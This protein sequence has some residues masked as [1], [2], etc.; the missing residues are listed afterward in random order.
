MTGLSTNRRCITSAPCLHGQ[1]IEFVIRYYSETTRQPEKAVTP[2]EAAAL[3][4]AGLRLAAV[5][6]DRAREPVDFSRDSGQRDGEF[7]HAYARAIGQPAGTTIFFAVDY[8]AAPADY[9]RLR[10][11]FTAVGAALTAAASGGPAY[12]VGVY[13]SGYVCRRLT[14]DQ[15]V[16]HR[17]LAEATGWRESRDATGWDLKQSVTRRGLCDLPA[18]EWQECTARG[19]GSG[20]AF[21]PGAPAPAPRRTAPATAQPRPSAPLPVL[22][23]GSRGPEALTLQ[24]LLNRWLVNYTALLREDG[25]FGPRTLRAVRAF[26]TAHTDERGVSLTPDGVVGGITWAALH[27]VTSGE[28]DPVPVLTA[29]TAGGRPW[30][31]S[32]PAPSYGGSARAR[33]ALAKA[34]EEAVSGAREIG[35]N[36]SGPYVEKYLADLVTPPANWCAGFVSWCLR[37]SGP[38]PFPYTVG[39]RSLL[40]RARAAGLTVY[41]DPI[42]TPPLPGD[43]VVWWRVAVGGWQGHTGFVHRAEAGRLYTLEGNKTSRV[44]GFDYPLVGL[45]K[46]LGLV[47]V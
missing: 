7:A 28:P 24:R 30:W 18:G 6:Q 2:A 26:Q 40:T 34:V 16:T 10:A 32:L 38:M 39:A 44:E 22:R 14:E 25:E 41:T 43:I 13:G 37:E 4:A 8:D 42:A 17:W 27:R 9:P 21:L 3:H 31:H 19:N 20:W 29:P 1:G 46:L 5:Y 36:N 23:R 12:R 35:G 11:Y 47:R 45:E 33:A 15:L